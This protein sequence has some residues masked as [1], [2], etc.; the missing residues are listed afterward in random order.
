MVPSTLAIRFHL[1]RSIS[2]RSIKRAKAE[3]EGRSGGVGGRTLEKVTR[4]LPWKPR[5][6]VAWY[7]IN[8][9]AAKLK[10]EGGGRRRAHGSRKSRKRRISSGWAWRE[11]NRRLAHEKKTHKYRQHRASAAEGR[12]QNLTQR[13][14]KK[15]FPDN[16]PWSFT[17]CFMPSAVETLQRYLQAVRGRLQSWGA[18]RRDK[19]LRNVWER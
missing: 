11:T 12:V 6:D 17:L 1:G 9:E 13:R 14:F 5:L 19:F 8:N 18:G 4:R 3:A 16:F 7:C 15:T 10:S 2:M